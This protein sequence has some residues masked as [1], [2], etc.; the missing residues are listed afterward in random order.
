MAKDPAKKDEKGGGRIQTLVVALGLGLIGGG[1]GGYLGYSIAPDP[2]SAAK[3]DATN[4]PDNS[5]VADEDAKKTEGAQSGHDGGS[6]GADAKP[7]GHEGKAGKAHGDGHDGGHG[8]GHGGGHAA[9]N[10]KPP[11]PPHA[12]PID[13]AVM[14]VRELPPVVTNLAKPE[15][16]WIRLQAAIVFD[17][18]DFPHAEKLTP[19]ILSDI[20]AYLRSLSIESLEGADGLRRL[21]EELDERVAIRSEH[22]VREF[23]IET[24]VVQ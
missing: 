15:T 7:S 22:K 13:F 3:D 2:A 21:Q 24:M 1:G 9:G 16:A 11:T 18:K 17:P 5:G 14:T 6:K 4:G 12:R 23:I 20:T 10:P 8:G 19:E